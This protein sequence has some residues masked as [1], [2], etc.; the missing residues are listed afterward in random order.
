MC[1]G[2]TWKNKDRGVESYDRDFTNLFFP[3]F[4][5]LTKGGVNV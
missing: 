1:G 3:N 5:Q 2:V 4:Q